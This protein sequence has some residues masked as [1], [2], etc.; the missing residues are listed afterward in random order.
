MTLGLILIV[1]GILIIGI[2]TSYIARKNEGI[3]WIEVLV[4]PIGLI[5]AMIFGH[6]ELPEFLIL[7]GLVCI[8]LGSLI[9]M[10][11]SIL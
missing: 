3:S 4:F 9:T 7:V 5:L 2:T 6:F 1:L 8:I 11:I 10:G